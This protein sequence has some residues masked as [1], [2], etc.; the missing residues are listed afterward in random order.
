MKRKTPKIDY[1]SETTEVIFPNEMIVGGIGKNVPLEKG[2]ILN[3]VSQMKE[4]KW[5]TAQY[6]E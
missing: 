4:K 5:S 1:L 3:I 6:F 2:K